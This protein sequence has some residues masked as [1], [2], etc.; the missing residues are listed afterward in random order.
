MKPLSLA[1]FALRPRG[2]CDIVP[3]GNPACCRPQAVIRS[4]RRFQFLKLGKKSHVGLS[5]RTQDAWQ[6]SIWTE[7]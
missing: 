1:D 2:R 3:A 5:A 6:T 7:V 4:V